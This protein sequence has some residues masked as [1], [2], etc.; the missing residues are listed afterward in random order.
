VAPTDVF[1][2]DTVKAVLL[3][4]VVTDCCLKLQ[5]CI[6][7]LFVFWISRVTS[8]KE[9]LYGGLLIELTAI[10][11]LAVVG[12][13]LM[14]KYCCSCKKFVDWVHAKEIFPDWQV[15]LLLKRL[16]KVV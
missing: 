14:V 9:L 4:S 11:R 12:E 15:G 10:T 16:E 5:T 2:L 7:K 13:L 1:Q 3:L 8:R 6:L